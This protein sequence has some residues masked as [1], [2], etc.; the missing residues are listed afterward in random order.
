MEHGWDGERA[1][2]ESFAR[3]W[4]NFVSFEDLDN[5]RRRAKARKL[6]G[7]CYWSE[8]SCW[9]RRNKCVSAANP[10]I[11]EDHH[12]ETTI[13]VTVLS[14]ATVSKL[15]MGCI[16]DSALAL[17]LG[18]VVFAVWWRRRRLIVF[19]VLADIFLY[20]VELLIASDEIREAIFNG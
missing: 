16:Y 8:K 4:K 10:K 1:D 15:S 17:P 18:L 14:A 13:E 20:T 6:S 5:V 9:R 3:V 11:N 12:L 2:R 19:E 7:L